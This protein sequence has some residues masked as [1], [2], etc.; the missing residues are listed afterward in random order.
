M[1]FLRH[2]KYANNADLSGFLPYLWYDRTIGW[3]RKDRLEILRAWPE[4]FSIN[5]KFVELSPKKDDYEGR[6]TCLEEA[7]LGLRAMGEIRGWR[8]EIY[9]LVEEFNAEPIAQLERAACPYLGMRSWGVH[10]T[11][12]VKKADGLYIWVAKRALSKQTYPA[13][14]DNMVAGGQPLGISP[15][16]N[17]QKEC[18]EEAGISL[19]IS[20]NLRPVGTVSYVHQLEEGIKP[21]QIFLYDLELPENF[22][23]INTDG[24]VESFSLLPAEEVMEMVRH[25][26]LVK[27]NCNLVFI[28]F[29][30]RHG[31]LSPDSCPD[32]MQLCLGLRK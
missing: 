12:Y 27:Y 22:Q 29:F 14:L 31:L 1:S 32:Y 11:G 8:D 21:D 7:L 15:T 9:P 5:E 2:I 20:K 24:E 26:D 16:E 28:D 3:I 19:D 13:M 17:M 25:T 30:L 18:W 4:A 6:S 10:L 23:P